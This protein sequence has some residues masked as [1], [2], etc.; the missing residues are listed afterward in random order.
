MLGELGYQPLFSDMGDKDTELLFGGA[1]DTDSLFGGP[2][3]DTDL[4]SL[5]TEDAPVESLPDTNYEPAPSRPLPPQLHLPQ[6]TLPVL[7]LPA[8]PDL[9]DASSLSHP[10]RHTSGSL[11]VSTQ[12]LDHGTPYP[13]S[14]QELSQGEVALDADFEQEWV[15]VRDNGQLVNAH[16]AHQEKEAARE[17][18]FE[19]QDL[20]GALN[21]QPVDTPI[22]SQQHAAEQDDSSIPVTRIPGF[23][24]ANSQTNTDLRVH[25]RADQHQRQAEGLLPYITLSKLSHSVPSPFLPISG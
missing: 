22:E 10:G 12:L 15:S 21:D 1:D 11:V 23:R 3:D 17:T 14:S 6:L 13:G 2:D 8:A 7:A 25:R 5:F 19:E 18:D 9:P 16:T 24:Y 20:V 4:T